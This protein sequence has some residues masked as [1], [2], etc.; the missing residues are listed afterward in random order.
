[1]KRRI[2]KGPAGDKGVCMI[3]NWQALGPLLPSYVEMGRTAAMEGSLRLLVPDL[4]NRTVSLYRRRCDSQYAAELKGVTA[5]FADLRTYQRRLEEAPVVDIRSRHPL[6][7]D[8]LDAVAGALTCLSAD[9][10]EASDRDARRA[11][12]NRLIWAAAQLDA[13]FPPAGVP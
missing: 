5:L 9:R 8:A 6:F 4:M 13:A 10:T 3:M 2:G 11:S 1:M 12:L 7:R